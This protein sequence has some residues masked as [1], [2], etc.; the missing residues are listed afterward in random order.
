M[1]VLEQKNKYISI[2]KTFPFSKIN[3]ICVKLS[4]MNP[5]QYNR[6]GLGK[7]S[8]ASRRNNN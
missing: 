2:E 3:Y 7:Q 6:A 4:H 5:L 1:L 8:F